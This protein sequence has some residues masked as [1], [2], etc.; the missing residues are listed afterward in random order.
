MRVY[1]AGPI[2]GFD[3]QERILTFRKYQSDLQAVGN[4]TVNPFDCHPLGIPW[5]E[6]MKADIK[7][8]VSCDAIYLLPGWAESKGARIE[9]NLAVDLGM[10]V[11]YAPR[12]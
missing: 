5:E 7:E 3:L 9:F 12:K 2:T 1:I 4:T 11:H 10:E 6:A 8:L